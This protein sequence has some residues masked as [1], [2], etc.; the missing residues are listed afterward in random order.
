M[1]GPVQSQAASWPSS[2]AYFLF[3]RVVALAPET[4]AAVGLFQLVLRVLWST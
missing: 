1:K 4:L 2:A 3:G